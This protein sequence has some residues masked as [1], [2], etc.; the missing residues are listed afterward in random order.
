M[1]DQK[2]NYK[3]PRRD[4]LQLAKQKGLTDTRVQAERKRVKQLKTARE[5]QPVRLIK[6]AA[7]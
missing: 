5:I 2:V 6:K 4:R 3:H 1:K 7:A